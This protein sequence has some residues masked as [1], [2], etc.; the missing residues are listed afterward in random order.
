MNDIEKKVKEMFPD[1]KQVECGEWSAF[2]KV[3]TGWEYLN[4]IKTFNYKEL[5]EEILKV[6]KNYNSDY[7]LKQLEFEIGLY[8]ELDDESTDEE[9]RGTYTVQAFCNDDVIF[10]KMAF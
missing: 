9:Y 2:A 4:E 6:C 8:H 3:I 1:W 7:E 10:C 5:D